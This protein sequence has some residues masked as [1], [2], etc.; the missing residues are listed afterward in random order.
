MIL[1]LILACVPDDYDSAHPYVPD[2]S[3]DTIDTSDT[4]TSG[5]TGLTGSWLSQG[6]DLSDLFAGDPFNLVQA[7]ATFRANGTYTAGAVDADNNSATFT[8]TY[9]TTGTSYPEVIALHQLQPQEAIASGIF[10][11]SGN[12]L[13]YEV[14]QT[15]PDN[16]FTP[17]TPSSGFGSTS[18]SNLAHGVNV[19]TYRR[20]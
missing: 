6:A 2:T 17:P 16:G 14:V 12:T 9:T 7:S 1:A 13:T 18:G 15:S 3:V 8:G 10:A 4:D 5:G 20:Q 19:Q 11:V